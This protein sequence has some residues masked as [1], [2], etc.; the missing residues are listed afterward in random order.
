M[1]IKMYWCSNYMPLVMF[2]KKHRPNIYNLKLPGALNLNSEACIL[3]VCLPSQD[4][5]LQD[6]R[7]SFALNVTLYQLLSVCL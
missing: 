1:N 7:I 3:A 4:P 5:I 2:M 6:R